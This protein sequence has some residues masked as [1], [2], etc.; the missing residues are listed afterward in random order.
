MSAL[1][2]SVTF[3]LALQAAGQLALLLD[4]LQPPA[5]T[6]ACELLGLSDEDEAA[7]LHGDAIGRWLCDP[8]YIRDCGDGEGDRLFS[9]VSSAGAIGFHTARHD[10]AQLLPLFAPPV[11]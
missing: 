9:L 5:E 1:D 4:G 8:I 2:A 11:V 10:A 6:S 7:D 3:D